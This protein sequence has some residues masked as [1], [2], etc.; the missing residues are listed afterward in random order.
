M[1][2][3]EDWIDVNAVP[4]PKDGEYLTYSARSAYKYG[5][6]IWMSDVGCWQHEWLRKKR[7]EIK[8][9]TWITH[10]VSIN[11]PN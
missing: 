7:S 9:K 3:A 5:V 11:P 10:Y 1:I 2:K 6:G 4:P 8:P